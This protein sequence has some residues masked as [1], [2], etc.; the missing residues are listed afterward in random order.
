MTRSDSQWLHKGRTSKMHANCMHKGCTWLLKGITRLHMRYPMFFHRGCTIHMC[1]QFRSPQSV[2][3][4]PLHCGMRDVKAPLTLAPLFISEN[5]LKSYPKFRAYLD[6]FVRLPLSDQTISQS[7]LQYLL[8]G[9]GLYI[10][11]GLQ[12]LDQKDCGYSYSDWKTI[13]HLSTR[14]RFKLWP[15]VHNNRDTGPVL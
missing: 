9:L 4:K 2:P 10:L 1:H 8:T 6:N 11:A 13:R 15:A 7:V 12:Q 3:R 5:I 14:L